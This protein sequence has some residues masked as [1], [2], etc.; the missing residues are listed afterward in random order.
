MKRLSI[1]SAVVRGRL[2]AIAD[3]GLVEL[4]LRLIGVAPDLFTQAGAA[5]SAIVTAQ[6]KNTRE[7]RPWISA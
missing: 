3:A 4:K 5:S 6:F 1:F 7:A 2:E